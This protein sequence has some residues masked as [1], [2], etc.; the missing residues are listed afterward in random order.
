MPLPPIASIKNNK[1]PAAAATLGIVATHPRKRKK[2]KHKVAQGAMNVERSLLGEGNE[3]KGTED[4][5]AEKK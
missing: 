4:K 5:M 3:K 2:Q 1:S